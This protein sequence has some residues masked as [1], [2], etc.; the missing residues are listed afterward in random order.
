MLDFLYFIYFQDIRKAFPD[1]ELI[2]VEIERGDGR[3]R[4]GA[5]LKLARP[6]LMEDWPH[7]RENVFVKNKASYQINDYHMHNTYRYRHSLKQRCGTCR[8]LTSFAGS[9]S[10]NFVMDRNHGFWIRN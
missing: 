3:Y 2:S 5:R 1:L 8:I 10:K 6:E 9:G 4:A 7:H